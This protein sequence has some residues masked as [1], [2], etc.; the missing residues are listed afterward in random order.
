MK[1]KFL[2]LIISF[3]TSLHIV[4]IHWSHSSNINKNILINYN[5]LNV[6]LSHLNKR[7]IKTIRHST[8]VDKNILVWLSLLGKD[9]THVQMV[10]SKLPTSL[11]FDDFNFLTSI[12]YFYVFPVG[13]FCIES[14]CIYYQRTF[15]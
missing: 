5:T 7:I 11:D 1:Q 9:Y 14:F 4:P 3:I 2:C 13:N 12:L 15:N 8:V 10:S 6:S